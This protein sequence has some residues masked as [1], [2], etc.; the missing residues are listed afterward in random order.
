MA[1]LSV[2]NLVFAC[3]GYVVWTILYQIIYYRFLHPLAKFPG[4]FWA[5]VTRLWIAWHNVQ[6]DECAAY[7][8]LHAKHGE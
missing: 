4:S 6:G 7:Q 8:K 5:S 1:V 2:Q 3:T